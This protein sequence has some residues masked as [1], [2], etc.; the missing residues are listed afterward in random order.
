MP[1]G[2][3]GRACYASAGLL[4]SYRTL[5]RILLGCRGSV[6]CPVVLSG[7]ADGRIAI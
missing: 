3:H 6:A 5:A 1:G 2:G 7:L 4:V